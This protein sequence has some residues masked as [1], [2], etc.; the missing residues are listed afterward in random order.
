[1]ALPRTS[2]LVSESKSSRS[3]RWAFTQLMVVALLA[4]SS[5]VN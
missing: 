3:V 2:R 4:S 5:R 1:M